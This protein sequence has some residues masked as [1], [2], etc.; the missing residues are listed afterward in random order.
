M[1][2]ARKNCTFHS[3]DQSTFVYINTCIFVNRG[4]VTERIELPDVNSSDKSWY[5]GG[6]IELGLWYDSFQ[7]VKSVLTL[8]RQLEACFGICDNIDRDLGARQPTAKRAS[9]VSC[10]MEPNIGSALVGYTPFLFP[11]NSI[12]GYYGNG[13]SR[14]DSLLS[15]SLSQ[16]QDCFNHN[17]LAGV[18]YQHVPLPRVY[19]SLGSWMACLIR[20]PAHRVG[21]DWCIWSWACCL[22]SSVCD[23][24]RVGFCLDRVGR[25]A[26]AARR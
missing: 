10:E 14:C 13:S 11:Q 17:W 25:M 8:L 5:E 21:R 22:A 20:H 12:W 23:G 2:N 19:M 3:K 7:P 1:K 24:F 4:L 26:I 18:A 6:Q 15:I 16:L 9:T